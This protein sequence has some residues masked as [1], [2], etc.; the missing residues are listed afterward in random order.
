MK[1][2]WVKNSTL[3]TPLSHVKNHFDR[4]L[5]AMSQ[6]LS[7]ISQF[8]SNIFSSFRQYFSVSQQYN[9][10]SQQYISVVEQY[11]SVSQQYFSVSKEQISVSQFYFSA[12]YLSLLVSQQSLSIKISN[13]LA[14]LIFVFAV[15]SKY[16]KLSELRKY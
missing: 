6:F 11:F 8:L 4:D 7:K 2:G 5:I 10:V 1:E 15:F 12:I 13:S 9:L 14:I 3:K 16:R